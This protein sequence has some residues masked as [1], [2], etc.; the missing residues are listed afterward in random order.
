VHSK[1]R[2]DEELG[3]RQRAAFTVRNAPWIV[4]A[5]SIA[6]CLVLVLLWVALE[7]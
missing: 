7:F 5:V 4:G 3:R 6:T 1:T 2:P